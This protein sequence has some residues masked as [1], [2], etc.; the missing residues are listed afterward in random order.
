LIVKIISI[1]TV[2]WSVIVWS[3]TR[4]TTWES[5]SVSISPAISSITESTTIIAIRSVKRAAPLVKS[6]ESIKSV[7]SISP[8]NINHHSG[9]IRG[10]K[11]SIT[12]TVPVVIITTIEG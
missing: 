8:A 5:Y 12:E 11:H 2:V 10:E 3:I 6:I 7:P 9:S 1:S 4:V